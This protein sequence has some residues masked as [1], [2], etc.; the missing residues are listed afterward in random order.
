[1]QQEDGVHTMV[2]NDDTMTINDTFMFCCRGLYKPCTCNC[3]ESGFKAVH[4]FKKSTN[5][6]LIPNRL[7]LHSWPYA[8]QP[9]DQLKAIFDKIAKTQGDTTSNNASS[10][11]GKDYD[12]D[13][14]HCCCWCADNILFIHQN[15]FW[16][17]F[18]LST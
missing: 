16:Q 12:D 10:A 5:S 11:I 6:S 13:N 15:C 4:M 17:R 3:K 8:H 18:S 14:D 7:Y 1:M 2:D 9:H